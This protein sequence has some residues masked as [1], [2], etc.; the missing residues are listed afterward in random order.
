MCNFLVKFVHPIST[1]IYIPIS[2]GHRVQTRIFVHT[3]V[4]N[5]IGEF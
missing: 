2:I 5:M 4:V 1:P 3:C